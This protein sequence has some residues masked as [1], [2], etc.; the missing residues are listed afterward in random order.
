MLEDATES[1]LNETDIRRGEE[2]E[3]QDVE[4][5]RGEHVFKLQD[6]DCVFEMYKADPKYFDRVWK[7][8]GDLTAVV[9]IG[10][11]GDELRVVAHTSDEKHCNGDC[12]VVI[13]DGVE[14]RFPCEKSDEKSARYAGRIT[15]PGPKSVV[16]IRVEDDDGHGKEGW[17]TT[18]RFRI[19]RN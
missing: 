4:L 1:T 17:V 16:E 7:G 15:C 12:L 11:V 8:W 13:V 5:G 14:R 18:G 9:K 19:K 6:F 3:I 2:G 10:L